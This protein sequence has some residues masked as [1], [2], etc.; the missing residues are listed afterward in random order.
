MTKTSNST[1]RIVVGVDDSDNSR[2]A[3]RWALD[4]ASA[5]HA[6][7][8]VVHAWHVPY[9]GDLSYT[10]AIMLRSEDF[11]KAAQAILDKVLHDEDTSAA[12]KVEA[13]LVRDS[14]AR[15][16]VEAAKDADLLVVGSRGLGGF[17]ELLLGS[18]S[19]QVV[20]HAPCPVVVVPNKE[21]P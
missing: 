10:S 12:A 7:V 16:L 2:A 4:E 14:A 17:R 11:E 6:E 13:A 1:F 9:V 20:H 5:R 15:A 3:L 19:S 8:R 18:T 21:E